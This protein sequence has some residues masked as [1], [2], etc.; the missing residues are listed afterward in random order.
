MQHY[1]EVKALEMENR[2]FLHV[3][4]GIKVRAG[5]SVSGMQHSY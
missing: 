3:L 1:A 4:G 2:S 5:R